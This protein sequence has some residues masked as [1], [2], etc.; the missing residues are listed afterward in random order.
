LDNS[1]HTSSGARLAD[2][3]AEALPLHSFIRAAT[4]ALGEMASMEV[5]V[6]GVHRT[7][8]DMPGGDISAVVAI[9]SA[10]DGLFVLSFPAGTA[11]AIA[12]RVLA[13][14]KATMTQS[15][16]EDCVGEIANV[17]AGQAKTLLA[18]TP[19]QLTYSLPEIMVGNQPESHLKRGHRCLAIDFHSDLG[20]FRLALM[21]EP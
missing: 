16:V 20:A 8:F 15:L 14:A 4:V 6:R 12:E 2:E 19:Y 10:T 5:A 11:A 9:R 17:I 1:E 3:D 7:T 18:G 21:L 13:D